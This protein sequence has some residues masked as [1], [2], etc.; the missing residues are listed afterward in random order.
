MVYETQMHIADEAGRFCPRE[1]LCPMSLK[2]N[3]HYRESLEAILSLTQMTGTLT[4][5]RLTRPC[6]STLGCIS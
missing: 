2:D 4:I 6:L 3:I 5:Q 1:I